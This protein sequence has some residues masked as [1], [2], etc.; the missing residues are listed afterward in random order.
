[1]QIASVLKWLGF[2]GGLFFL[3]VGSIAFWIASVG[4]FEQGWTGTVVSGIAFV[5]AALPLLAVP[6]SLHVARVFL[7]LF[8][9]MLAGFMVVAAFNP[10]ASVTEPGVYQV[11]AIAL[12]VLVVSRVVFAW[13][14]SAPRVRT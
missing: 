10:P 9:V 2:A 6:F 13:R 4:T 11:A 7:A 3:G 8:L 14:H 12:A 5:M 1:M